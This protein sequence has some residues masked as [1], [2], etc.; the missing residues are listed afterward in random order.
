MRGRVGAVNM[1]FVHTSSQLGELE[2]GVAAALF[3]AVPAAALGAL[4]TIAVAL[5]WMKL[6]PAVRDF[7]GGYEPAR[8]GAEA[9]KQWRA[10]GDSMHSATWSPRRSPVR[11]PSRRR[12]GA[13]S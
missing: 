10:S 13:T 12:S 7:A 4:G 6:F 5:L 11:E 3:G 8:A 1:L 9:K 2:S